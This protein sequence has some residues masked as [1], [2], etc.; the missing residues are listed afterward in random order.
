MSSAA[1]KWAREQRIAHA[2]LTHLTGTLAAFSDEKGVTWR[3]QATLAERMAV[4]ER[5]VR[6]WLRALEKLG[7][8]QR[9]HRSNGRGG[10]TSDLIRL[11]LDRQFTLTREAVRAILLPEQRAGKNEVSYR[12]K[13][14]FLPEQRAGEKG[15]DPLKV[16]M[17]TQE[18]LEPI[19]QSAQWGAGLRVVNGGRS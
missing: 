12:N 10:R 11:R 19:S 5:C 6:R 17:G 15:S 2:G 18:G 1:M 13:T 4:T 3:S 14:S 9:A 8:I 16:E 7:V